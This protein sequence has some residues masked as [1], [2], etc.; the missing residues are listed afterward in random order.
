MREEVVNSLKSA[1]VKVWP[2]VF[3]PVL[4]RKVKESLNYVSVQRRIKEMEKGGLK[5]VEPWAFVRV[6]NERKTL[7]ASL[8][9]MLPAIKKGVIAYND[10]TDGSDLIIKE[11][12]NDHPGFIPYEYP[13]YVEPPGSLKYSTGE[14]MY[15]NTLA[16]YY[17]AVMERI[18]KG[19]WLMKI[20]V[21][22]I[23]FPEILKHSF[24]LPKSNLDVVVYSRLDVIRDN[25]GS[26]K[27]LK[28][29]RPGDQWLIFNDGNLKFENEYGYGKDGSYR[30]VEVLRPGKRRAYYRPECSNVHFPFEKEGRDYCGSFDGLMGF[31]EFFDTC[32]ER[33]ISVDLLRADGISRSEFE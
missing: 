27:V 12:C 23:Y 13:L 21:D 2:N 9:S 26:L 7:L 15:E 16:A 31:R 25:S 28:Y 11:F 18:P 20:D 30:A 3:F 5:F 6:K 4:R 10:C 32:D 24:S 17:N 8:N 1:I 22:H 29:A 14:L 19:E 33:E